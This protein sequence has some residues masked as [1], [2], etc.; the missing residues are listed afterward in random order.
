MTR[1]SYDAVEG[2]FYERSR[3]KG[4]PERRDV[5]LVSSMVSDIPEFITVPTLIERDQSL[6]N[7]PTLSL[8]DCDC[9]TTKR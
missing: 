9:K 2:V 8:I 6:A 4:S 7:N 5:G 3:H 1:R